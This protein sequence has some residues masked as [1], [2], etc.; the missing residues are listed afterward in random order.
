MVRKRRIFS[1]DFKIKVIREIEQGTKQAEICR[2]HNLH[3]VMVNLWRREYHQCPET[4]FQEHGRQYKDE[5]KI[6][7]LEQLVGKLY[8]ENEFLKKTLMHLEKEEAAETDQ[9]EIR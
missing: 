2:K 3:P 1:R 8:I 4:A 7:E 9:E 5:A 6:A